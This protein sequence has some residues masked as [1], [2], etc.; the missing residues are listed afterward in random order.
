M[1]SFNVP[2]ARKARCRVW[3][4]IFLAAFFL[5]AYGASSA[6]AMISVGTL[7]QEQAQKKY[8]ITMHARKNG[9]AGILVWL[10]FKKEGWLKKFTY[11]ELHMKNEQGKHLVSAKL[12][13]RPVKHGQSEE[14]TT[15]SFSADSDQLKNC[16]FLV[17]SY[18]GIAGG[19]GY[20]L[21]VRDFIDLNDP[22][23]AK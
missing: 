19:V 4:P 22:A 10:E 7:N 13:P 21:N 5:L 3:L 1:K 17:V 14:I 15:V 8:G 16:S 11:A 23:L 20:Y 9:D 2:A 18:Q 6:Y 12:E